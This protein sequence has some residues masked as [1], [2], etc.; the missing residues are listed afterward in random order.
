MES[1]MEQ[2]ATRFISEL[3][4]PLPLGASAPEARA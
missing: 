4:P 1:S 2:A 3:T